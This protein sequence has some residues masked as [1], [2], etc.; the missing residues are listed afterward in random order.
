MQSFSDLIDQLGGAAAVARFA[1]LKP[2]TVQ[3]MKS[4]DSVQP[5]YWPFLIKLAQ[6]KQVAGVTHDALIQLA[7]RPAKHREAA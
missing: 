5:R 6:Q 4:R 3:Q 1:G 7:S 2:G